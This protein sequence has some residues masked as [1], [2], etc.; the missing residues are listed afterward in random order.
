M[1]SSQMDSTVRNAKLF[2][3]FDSRCV[4]V[5]ASAHQ[6]FCLSTRPQPNEPTSNL[7]RIPRLK[8]CTLRPRAQCDPAAEVIW[9]RAASSAT[10]LRVRQAQLSIHIQNA[11]NPADPE[12]KASLRRR[13][14][15]R[16]GTCS[17][18]GP[19][20][21]ATPASTEATNQQPRKPSS[22]ASTWARPSAH[23]TSMSIAREETTAE[24]WGANMYVFGR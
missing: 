12:L 18:R 6:V 8:A 15:A 20:L 9:A 13:A 7:A 3:P 14:F 11:Q 22:V 24:P 1:Q 10:D 4:T 23:V 16:A 19:T 17:G 5:G 2:F 21:V